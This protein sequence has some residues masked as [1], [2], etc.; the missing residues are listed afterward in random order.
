MMIDAAY[1]GNLA[2]WINHSCD[3]NCEAVE[4]DGRI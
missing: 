2:R 4:E 3:P 1:G